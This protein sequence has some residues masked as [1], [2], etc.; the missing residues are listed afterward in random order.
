MEVIHQEEKSS[1]EL[2]LQSLK[3]RGFKTF[4]GVPDSEFKKLIPLLINDPEVNYIPSVREDL[5]IAVAAGAT[6][7][8]N[9]SVV[10]M[11]NSGLGTSC[12]VL[13]SLISVYEIPVLLFIA[14]AGHE[15]KDVPHHN[16]MGLAMC[17]ILDAMNIPYLVL[18]DMNDFEDLLAT[19]EKYLSNNQTVAMLF[20]PGVSLR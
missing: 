8:G 17:G 6:L 4:A 12:D 7:G 20:I 9:R 1:S 10:F 2:I 11:E 13:T 5:A 14:W 18:K 19:A 15:G 3:K 16:V